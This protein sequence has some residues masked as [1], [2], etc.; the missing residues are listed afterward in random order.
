MQ[1]KAETSWKNAIN[2]SEFELGHQKIKR[3][4]SNRREPHKKDFEIERAQV[5][6]P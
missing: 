3:N 4:S 6:N 5:A 1:L 2:R